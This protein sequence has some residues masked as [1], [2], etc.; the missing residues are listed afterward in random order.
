[1][2]RNFKRIFI[3]ATFAV[4]TPMPASAH[5]IIVKS[6]PQAGAVLAGPEIAIAFTYNVR[7]DAERSKLTLIAADGTARDVAIVP[8]EAPDML[9]GIA[10]GIAPGAYVLRW[11]VLA[12]DG[13]ITRGDVP[14][15]IAP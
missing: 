13:H 4:A 6:E 3:L 9:K 2:W 10:A 15:S 8:D 5:A 1:M 7:I 12:S 14:F 11:Q